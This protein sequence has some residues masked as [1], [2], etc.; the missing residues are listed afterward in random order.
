VV[1][2]GVGL[3]PDED[4]LLALLGPLMSI[5]GGE[6][7]LT[8]GGPRRRVEPLGDRGLRVLELGF[9]DRLEQFIE[10]AR[11]QPIP[12]RRGLVDQALSSHVVR[13]DPLRQ[14]GPLADPRLQQP[15]L[16]LF[17]RELDVAHVLEVPLEGVH[18]LLEL[19]E[20]AR[21]DVAHLLELER[22]TD[23]RDDVLSLGIL[24]I[25]PVTPLVAV[26]GVTRE[27]DTRPRIVSTVAEDHRLHVDGGAER[28]GDPVPPA[29]ILRSFVVPR[30]EH[31]LDGLVELLGRIL[32]ELFPRFLLDDLLELFDELLQVLRLEV[33]IVLH[34]F[35]LLGVIEGVLEQI[36]FDP[37]HRLPEHLQE[38]AVG[39]PGEPLG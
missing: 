20:G 12:Y 25:V 36:S 11:G 19:P 33:D 34:A 35:L 38:T 32:R 8:D 28:I 26:R 23:A 2:V 21:L 17:D 10:L 4:H 27:G 39:I 18:M 29:V 16:A 22:V 6:D 14:R 31:R 30:P 1:I 37:H 7:R 13:D 9:D 5:V 24:Q 15:Q 3:A